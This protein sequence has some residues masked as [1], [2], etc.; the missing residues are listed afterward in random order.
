MQTNRKSELE[1]KELGVAIRQRRKL[2]EMTLD[3]LAKEVQVDVGQLSRFERG[4]FKYSSKNLQKIVTYLQIS[5]AKPVEVADPLIRKF[6][7]LLLRSE[8]HRAAATALVH[9]L[10]ELR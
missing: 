10:E 5:P 9:A 4:E 6:A 7:E 1:V 8:R 3:E 2:L